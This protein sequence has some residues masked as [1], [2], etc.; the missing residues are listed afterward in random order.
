MARM[1]S[2]HHNT[3]AITNREEKIS[4]A[5]LASRKVLLL[6]LYAFRIEGDCALRDLL[7]R[8]STFSDWCM[9]RLVF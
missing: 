9:I 3:S 4:K 1:G 8:R 2:N 6:F 7:L 5:L